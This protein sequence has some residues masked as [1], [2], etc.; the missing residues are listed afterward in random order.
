MPDREKLQQ[1]ADIVRKQLEDH[2]EL[3]DEKREALEK[4][5]AK[6]ELQLQLEPATQSPSIADDVNRAVEGFELDHP[7][8]AGV[9]RNIVVTLGGIG[10]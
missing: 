9:L 6:F 8:I 10:I 3:P 7:G 1:Q 4:L 5:V 2:P